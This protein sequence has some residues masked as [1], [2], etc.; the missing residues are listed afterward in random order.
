[1]AKQKEKKEKKAESKKKEE[2]EK[3]AK[4]IVGKPLEQEKPIKELEEEVEEELKEEE[5]VKEEKEIVEKPAK[6]LEEEV[7]NPFL[8]ENRF[9]EFFQP[10]A[11]SAPAPARVAPAA[12]REENIENLTGAAETAAATGTTTT[13]T[14][15]EYAPRKV[16]YVTR[17]GG[18]VNEPEYVSASERLRREGREPDAGVV[19]DEMRKSKILIPREE[20]IEAAGR[21]ERR[22][23]EIENP[24][25]RGIDRTRGLG[26]G[27]DYVARAERHEEDKGLPFERRRRDYRGKI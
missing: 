25:L 11:V 5:K 3:K 16:E 15:V 12:G 10:S 13:P 19:L 26:F 21:R 9:V 1:M 22:H 18:A 23:I 2:K 24:E 7:E 27:E 14:T 20:I 17:T 4:E 8:D 6:E